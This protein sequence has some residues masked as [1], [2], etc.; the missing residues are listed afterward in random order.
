[1]NFDF[2]LKHSNNTRAVLLFHGMTGS[3]Y[4]LKKFGQYLFKNGFDV[5][6]EC[7]PGH[8]KES[9]RILEVTSD[10]WKTFAYKKFETLV[11]EYEEVF[12]G[13]LC[14]GALL[15]LGVAEKYPH[16][17]KGVLAL[18]T[19]LYLD[20]T[21]MPWYSFLL[22]LGYMTITRYFYRYPEGEPYGIKNEKTRYVVKKLLEKNQVGMDNFPLTCIYELNKLSKCVQKDLKKIFAPIL[23]IHSFEDDLA[24]PQGACKVFDEISSDDKRLIILQDSYHMVLYDNEKDV[25]F[26]ECS[27]FLKKHSDTKEIVPC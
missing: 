24:S 4:E 23:L 17:V 14:L 6:A 3:P 15:A 18:S 19:T 13:G 2:E 12:V 5:F 7:L 26:F 16:F 21:R 20:G 1:M 8:G 10:D 27:E 11:L 9:E 22:P 25:V